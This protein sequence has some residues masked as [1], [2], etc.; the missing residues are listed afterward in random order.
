MFN[1]QKTQDEKA[2][3]KKLSEIC[4]SFKQKYD[5]S[6]F[7]AKCILMLY[8][9][10]ECIML[11]CISMC[12][13]N[14]CLDKQE[15]HRNTRS[16]FMPRLV[17]IYNRTDKYLCSLHH[18]LKPE[19]SFMLMAVCSMFLHELF[20]NATVYWNLLSRA[21]RIFRSGEHTLLHEPYRIRFVYSRSHYHNLSVSYPQ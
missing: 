14:A 4:I 21:S 12:E 19:V 10:Y 3:T 2:I 5:E 15:A 6:F 11:E 18:L 16:L 1:F 9:I 20:F 7:C 8:R 17:H 13:F